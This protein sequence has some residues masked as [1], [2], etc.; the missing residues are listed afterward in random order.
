MIENIDDLTYTCTCS[1]LI[2][3]KYVFTFY[4]FRP[5]HINTGYKQVRHL[6]LPAETVGHSWLPPR[7]SVVS[8]FLL[9]L[10]C[11]VKSF[12]QRLFVWLDSCRAS[13]RQEAE[14]H[15]QSLQEAIF[16][17]GSLCRKQ[18]I[19][20]SLGGSQIW[21]KS[22]QEGKISGIVSVYTLC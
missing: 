21:G 16:V 20:D 12:L 15:G 10:L 3:R 1:I 8:C 2:G 4:A 13:S 14:W 5:L 6:K 9:R 17:D 11:S 7:L 22:L 19:M 18:E